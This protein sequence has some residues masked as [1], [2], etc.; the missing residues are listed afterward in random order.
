MGDITFESLSLAST[1]SGTILD[2]YDDVTNFGIFPV[3]IHVQRFEILFG[4]LERLSLT[5]EG[6]D[7]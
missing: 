3:A 7:N 1:G 5:K 2:N 4:I 6:S